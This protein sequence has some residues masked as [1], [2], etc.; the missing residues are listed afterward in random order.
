MRNHHAPCTA[1]LLRTRVRL[2][3]LGRGW[4]CIHFLVGE[5]PGVALFCEGEGATHDLLFMYWL[6]VEGSIPTPQSSKLIGHHAQVIS[7]CI[8]KV[9]N[10][11][12]FVHY[13]VLRRIFLFKDCMLYAASK[14]FLAC[15][16]ACEVVD[17]PCQKT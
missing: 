12:H 5:F 17:G 11:F 7:L 16:H 4:L 13:D 15:L 10:G 3:A 1:V 6:V 2:G 8:R 9:K 14:E